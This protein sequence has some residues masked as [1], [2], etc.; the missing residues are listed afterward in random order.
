MWSVITQF[1]T[2]DCTIGMIYFDKENK[3]NIFS[4]NSLNICCC[5]WRPSWLDFNTCTNVILSLDIEKK[6]HRRIYKENSWAPPRTKNLKISWDFGK[7][8]QNTRLAWHPYKEFWIRH[9]KQECIPLGCVPP[10]CA[11]FLD[12]WG[13]VVDLW[14]WPVEMGSGWPLIWAGGGSGWPLTLVLSTS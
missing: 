1:D 11:Q 10:V 9:C 13:E 12:V 8:W 2:E 14:P 5:I 4:D 3:Y 7:C 6:K